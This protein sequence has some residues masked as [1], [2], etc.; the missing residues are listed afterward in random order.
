MP[1]DKNRMNKTLIPHPHTQ[2]I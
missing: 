1:F 2:T